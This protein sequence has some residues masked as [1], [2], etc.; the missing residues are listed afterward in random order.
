[1]ISSFVD[2]AL[3]RSITAVLGR[4]CR[5][6]VRLPSCRCPGY[7]VCRVPGLDSQGLRR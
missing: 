7:A 5:A 1:M 4:D 2:A 3:A 6:G